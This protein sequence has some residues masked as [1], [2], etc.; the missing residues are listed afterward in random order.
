MVWK[1]KKWEL[2]TYILLILEI[3]IIGKIVGIRLGFFW[4]WNSHNV[5]NKQGIIFH[6]YYV[7]H[8]SRMHIRQGAYKM[9]DN[10]LT[11]YF[12]DSF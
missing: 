10:Y 11:S 6:F 8:D 7:S 4:C 12:T 9:A 1:S 3:S 2:S 5:V